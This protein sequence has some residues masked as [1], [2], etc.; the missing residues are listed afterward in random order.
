MTKQRTEIL[1]RYKISILK[2][3]AA[4]VLATGRNE[5]SIRLFK[6]DVGR[7]STV[8][9]LRYHGLIHHVLRADGTTKRGHWLITRNGWAF[10]KGDLP[11]P[12]EVVVQDNHIVSRSTRTIRLNQAQQPDYDKHEL[13]VVKTP[14]NLA[15]L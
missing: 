5:F 10:L 6:S 4:H 7:Y 9:R 8:C 15:L 3:A 1:D 2:D 12:V 13:P 14:E 11:L